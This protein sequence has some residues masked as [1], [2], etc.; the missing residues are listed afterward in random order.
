[1]CTD[2]FGNVIPCVLTC[3]DPNGNPTYCKVPTCNQFNGCYN[4]SSDLIWR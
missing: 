1:M 3:T 4:T 2:E